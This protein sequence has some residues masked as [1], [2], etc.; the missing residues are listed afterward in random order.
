MNAAQ[1]SL[2]ARAA[3]YR[4]HSLVDSKEHIKPA[5]AGFI[6]KFER[7]VD[8]HSQLSPAERQR[9][10]QAALKSHML[11]LARKSANARRAKKG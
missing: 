10:A 7:E 1:R 6:A 9:R 4:L 11:T 5:R 3:A 2:A 8:P